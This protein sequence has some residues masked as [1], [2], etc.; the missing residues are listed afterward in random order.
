MGFGSLIAIGKDWLSPLPGTVLRGLEYFR[1]RK[2]TLSHHAV[3]VF[4]VN[5]KSVKKSSLMSWIV[6]NFDRDKL[7]VH[8]YSMLYFR[9]NLIQSKGL[10]F[11]I[12]LRVGQGNGKERATA[13]ANLLCWSLPRFR[14]S[15]QQFFQVKG[16]KFLCRK[17]NLKSKET[18]FVAGNRN[19]ILPATLSFAENENSFLS[20]TNF[21]AGN[22]W[23]FAGNT[24]WL[25][26]ARKKLNAGGKNPKMSAD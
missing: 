15:R 19:Y 1:H 23:Q 5:M 11:S 24:K 25:F 17:R 3:G 14:Q 7:H 10:V 16:N 2:L 4:L 20:A 13:R 8:N 6:N 18:T 26:P 21:F 12:L 22:K 9:V